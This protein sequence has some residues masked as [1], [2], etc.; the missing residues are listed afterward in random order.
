M[1][2]KTKNQTFLIQK[3][4]IVVTSLLLSF[5]TNGQE[6]DK[7]SLDLGAGVQTIGAQINTGYSAKIFGQGNLGVR[8][9]FNEKFG[10]RLDLGY[11]KIEA[12]SSSLPFSSNY[13]RASVQGVIN[14][15]NVLK[16]NTWT[17][18]INLLAHGGIGIGILNNTIPVVSGNE[19]TVPISLGI[20]PQFKISERIAIFADFSS[21]INF[22]QTTTF[23]GTPF[24]DWRESNVSLFNT[25]IGLNIA[26]GRYRKLADFHYEESKPLKVDN[27]LD[28]IKKR[29]ASAEKE[30]KEL[31]MESA[32]P[33]KEL[34][35]TELDARYVKKEELKTN[36]YADVISGGNV[37]FIKELLNRGFINVYF[38]TNKSEIQKGSLNSVNYMKQFL[39]DNPTMS[40]DIIGYADETGSVESNKALSQ[41]RAKKVYDTLIAAGISS[42]RLSYF[43]GGV[44]PS[45][46]EDARQFARKVVFKL[47]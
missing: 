30:I 46:S 25:S 5:Q 43:G 24:T 10:L 45:V 28:Q 19:F 6:F 42:S 14:V 39:M 1:K 12:N 15:G 2:N 26:F 18:R 35:M 40:A 21:I 38:D 44:D 29:L 17:N 11:N 33:N 34:I 4:L 37:D 3:L 36:K 13:Y 7:W 16:F 9:M 8:Y 32:G 20:T 41:K 31:K 47:R 22:H 27:E 23:N